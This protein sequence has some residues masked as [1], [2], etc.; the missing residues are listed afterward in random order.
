MQALDLADDPAAEQAGPVAPAQRGGRHRHGALFDAGAVVVYLMLAVA[1]LWDI[2]ST[3]PTSVSFIG[4]DQFNAM[5]VLDW[6]PFALTHGLNPLNH[7]HM[8]P[9]G[10]NAMLIT[11]T[12]LLG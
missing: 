4:G 3:H 2:W 12:P 7:R 1:V 9:Y 5:W 11:S 6:F 8:R 10:A